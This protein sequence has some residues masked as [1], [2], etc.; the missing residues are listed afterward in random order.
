MIRE[1]RDEGIDP[2][3]VIFGVIVVFVLL[4]F[5]IMCTFVCFV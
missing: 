2:R 1:K 5:G 3:S 4:F